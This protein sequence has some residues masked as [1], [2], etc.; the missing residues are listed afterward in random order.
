M[1]PGGGK[2]TPLSPNSKSKQGLTFYAF[3]H[4]GPFFTF[5]RNLPPGIG[6]GPPGTGNKLKE[7]EKIKIA[8]AIDFFLEIHEEHDGFAFFTF[9]TFWSKLSTLGGGPSTCNYPV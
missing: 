1:E 3:S 4:F 8:G 7:S 2:S 9:F 5:A 6:P